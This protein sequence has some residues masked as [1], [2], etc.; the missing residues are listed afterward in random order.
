MLK[1]FEILSL[2]GA[3]TIKSVSRP[4]DC[5]LPSSSIKARVILRYLLSFL[6]PVIVIAILSIYWGY[7]LLMKHRS[8]RLYFLRRLVLVVITVIYITY[9]DITQMAVSV[10]N[11]VN[12][13]DGGDY[14]FPTST[15]YWIVDTSIKCY[16]STHFV[17]VG[18]SIGALIIVSICFPLACSWALLRTRNEVQ[19][20]NSRTRE[21]LGLLYGPF[22]QGF[23]FWECVTMLKKA[24]LSVMIV[25]SY[26]SGDQVQGL[27]ISLVL[28]F[29][30]SLHAT[31][32]PF[33]RKFNS[34]NYYESGSLLTSC[35]TYIL[36]QFFNVETLSGSARTVISI[37]LIVLN[38]G[39]V[40]VMAF[41][42]VQNFVQLA[43]A[44][45]L[46]NN[47]Q[48]TD[49][50]SWSSIGKLYFDN[51]KSIATST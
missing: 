43:R 28:V 14:N 2:L 7:R 18:F 20:N 22:K 36:V 45:L 27:L 46:S 30:L 41:V 21:T 10:F 49:N 42:I 1:F 40:L 31:C 25:S 50:T 23:V 51:R 48:V 13:H 26:S 6:A 19:V 38:G 24:L 33:E 9:F 4:I 5:I 39:F 8:E 34:L 37:A 47:V 3:A 11:C 17:L 29:F 32:W 35:T 15:R 16:K 44:I 12:V